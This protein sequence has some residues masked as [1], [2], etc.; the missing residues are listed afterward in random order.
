M[1]SVA[2]KAFREGVQAK[3]RENALSKRNPVTM[4]TIADLDKAAVLAALFNAARRPKVDIIGDD[5]LTTKEAADA[6]EHNHYG[7]HMMFLFN[8]T[9][10]V[11][12]SKD[13]IDV[14]PYNIEN[15]A[16]AAETIIETLRKK[17]KEA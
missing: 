2:T 16:D 8:R 7:S 12:F 6:L 17:Q 9:I 10:M 14:W 3:R 1:E 15:G 5:L 13:E 11:D 4:V